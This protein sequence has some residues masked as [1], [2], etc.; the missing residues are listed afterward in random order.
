MPA[1]R[2]ALYWLLPVA[3]LVGTWPHWRWL[4]Q[5]MTD[6]SDEPWGGVALLTVAVLAWL[7][8]NELHPPKP[9]VLAVAAVLT[10]IA[11]ASWGVLPA[12]VA[13][14]FA[15]LAVATLVAGLLP[16][17][18][19]VAALLMLSLLALPLVAS[20]NFYLGYP[21]RWLCAQAAAGILSL[22]GEDVT[23]QGAALWWNGQPVLIDAACAGIAMLWIGSYLAALF[24]YL[25]GAGT[26]R[27]AL[28][29]ALATLFV[30]AANILRN[31]L[32]FYKEAGI[33][34]LPHWTH[35]AIGLALFGL[36]VPVLYRVC[37][38]SKTTVT[39]ART[40][41]DVGE[42]IAQTP[43]LRLFVPLML[44][45][46]LRPLWVSE[47]EGAAVQ[48]A[49]L[50]Q[51]WAFAR[52]HHGNTALYPLPLSAVDERFAHGFPGQI[53][54]FSDGQNVWVVRH[55]IQPTRQLHPAAD[56]YRGLGYHVGKPHVLERPDHTRWQ[57][58]STERGQQ[59][60]VCE[61]IFDAQGGNWTDVSAWY[62]E[63]VFQSG[64]HEWWAVT[65]VTLDGQTA[66]G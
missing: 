34:P 29:L 58:F 24:S 39:H 5:R 18:R 48:A 64:S 25:N 53:G 55:I 10:G 60:R 4:A 45:C 32:L 66:G 43:G 40:E 46:A 19:P 52:W 7:D 11:S 59:W 63:T 12:I 37:A 57:C 54:K 26:G 8:R 22:L 1:K 61:R 17:R 49:Q 50:E 56:C 36:L 31:T 16:P 62:W 65:Q 41:P 21:L 27:C 51:D 14:A 47:P 42:N 23:P 35:E 3:V 28:N 38:G 9:K 20:L 33:V 30:L 2:P 15:L 44:I 6:G 13:S